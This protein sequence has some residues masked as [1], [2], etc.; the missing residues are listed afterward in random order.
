MDQEEDG[1]RGVGETLHG[2]QMAARKVPPFITFNEP[3]NRSISLRDGALARGLF[4]SMT[5]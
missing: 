2:Q 3:T 5:S 1:Q 4:F